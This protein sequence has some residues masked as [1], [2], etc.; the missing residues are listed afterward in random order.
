MTATRPVA[1][2]DFLRLPERKPAL[3]YCEGRIT[4]KV[5]PKAKHSVLQTTLATAINAF[6]VPA[7][8]AFAFNELR[9][10]FAGASRVPDIA[11]YRWNRI[12]RD[13][14]GEP[15]DDVFEPPDIAIEIASPDQNINSLI[16]RCAWFVSNGVEIALLINAGNR[17]V[18]RFRVSGQRDVLRGDDAVDLTPVLPGFHITVDE[19][20]ALLKLE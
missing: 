2:E 18:T 10:T 19:L 8:I 3:E 9:A 17:A 7:K 20:F 4:Q 5:S 11:I 6:A 12:S 1:L 14:S 16:R 15:I 13:S